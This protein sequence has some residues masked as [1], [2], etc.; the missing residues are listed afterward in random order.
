M[1]FQIELSKILGIFMLGLIQISIC[2]LYRHVFDKF[3]A[4]LLNVWIVVLFRYIISSV[5]FR[6]FPYELNRG[7]HAIKPN[8]TMVKT[9][10]RYITSSNFSNMI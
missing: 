7:L 5:R 6:D 1:P 10:H 2:F 3:P 9:S 8:R 4:S